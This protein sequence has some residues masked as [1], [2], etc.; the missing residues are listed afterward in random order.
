[1]DNS[2]ELETSIK[3]LK[4]NNYKVTGPRK[5]IL[6]YMISHRTHP[7]V[8]MIHADLKDLPVSTIYNTLELLVKNHIVITIDKIND[9]KKHYDYFGKP[10]YHVI[11]T[12]C[13]LI[14]DADNFD[15]KKLPSK[16]Q[17]AT[18][19]RVSGISV[20]VFGLCPNCQK[21]LNKD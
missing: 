11:C 21:L 10:H 7:T 17:E 13:G 4:E 1:M 19:Y 14:T 2:H 16:A 9:D 8:E 3:H 12:N 20:E 15:F 6:E 18:N 5:E